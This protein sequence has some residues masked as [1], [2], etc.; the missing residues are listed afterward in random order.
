[1]KGGGLIEGLYTLLFIAAVV[2]SMVL[3]G[4]LV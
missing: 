3:G 4:W 2:G 1:M